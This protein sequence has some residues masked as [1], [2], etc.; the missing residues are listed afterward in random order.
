MIYLHKIL[1]VFL[2]PTGIT[3]LLVITGLVLRKRALCWIGI[4][5]LWL[6]SMPIVADAVMG[7]AEG[8]QVRQPISAAPASEAIVVLSGGRVQ[9]PGDPGTSEWEDADRFYA[10]VELYKAKKAPLLIFTGGW[11]PWLPDMKPEG[12]VL[13]RYAADLGVP[14]EH[15]LTTARVVNTDE[16]ARAVAG[17][18]VSRFGAKANPRVLLVTSAYGM[19]RAVMLFARAGVNVIP[20]PVDFR[21]SAGER[22]SILKFLPSAASLSTTESAIREFYGFHYYSLFAR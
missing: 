1:P 12:E 8:W 18:L 17:L 15:M 14:H 9:P 5:V 3:L 20:F 22:I 6:A 11:A 16:E 19:R 10:G 4:A 7:A 21:V 2:L 13:I